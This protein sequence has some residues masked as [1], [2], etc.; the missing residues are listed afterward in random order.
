MID[1]AT[2]TRAEHDAAVAER[3][4]KIARLEERVAKLQHALWGRR[5]EK[6]PVSPDAPFQSA[7]F[8]EECVDLPPDE[9]DSPEPAEQQESTTAGKKPRR[10]PRF[11]GDVERKVIDI[12]LPESER[13]CSCCGETMASIGFETAERAHYVPARMEIHEERRHK[14]ACKCKEGG[15]TTAPPTPTLFPKSR[16]TDDTRVQVIVSKFVDHL[17][18]YRQSAILR[19]LGFEISD[20]TLGRWGIEAADRLAPIIIAMHEELLSSPVLQADETTL[21]VL[22]TEKQK[23]GAHRGWLWGYAIPR[24]SIVFDYTRTRA[25]NH[26][27]GFLAG[28]EGLLQ[29]DRYE[30]YNAVTRRDEV[31]DVACWAHARRRFVE[32]ERTNGRK[33]RPVLEVIGRLYAVEKRAR[34]SG[35]PPDERSTLRKAESVPILEELDAMLRDLAVDVLPS[36]ALGD[37]VLYTLRHWP[38]L[39]VYVD[40]GLAEIDNNLIEN[41]MRPIALGRKNWLFAGSELGA[42]AAAIL[43]SLT[44]SCRRLGIDPHEYLLDVMERLAE[45]DPTDGD[46]IRALTPA[47]WK[48]ERAIEA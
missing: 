29:V 21:P 14:Y 38:A 15:V 39:T 44:E 5:S 9:D 34:D 24:G 8:G 37:A 2:I 11:R 20:A 48:A 42:E 41:S 4:A 40:H 10:K 18:Y 19:R 23:P 28:Y 45:I 7:L 17:P 46:A 13:Q 30:G 33:A 16:V 27:L 31:I 43:Y 3:D 47:R 6:Q 12:E 22:K 26:P 32:A 25:Q 35:I 36:S 1:A